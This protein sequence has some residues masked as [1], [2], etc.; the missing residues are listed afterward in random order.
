MKEINQASH[1]RVFKGVLTLL[2]SVLLISCASI[3]ELQVLYQL[4]PLSTQLEGRSVTLV[5]DDAR[6]SK[7]ILGKGAEEEFKGFS[8]SI[9]LSVA[10]ANKKGYR[11]GIF[12][13]PQLMREAFARKLETSGVKVLSEKTVGVPLLVIVLK[14]F[15]LDLVGREWLAKMSYEARLKG[16]KGAVANQ[17]INGK[18]ERYKLIGRD[19]ADTLMGEI[20]SDMVNALDLSRLFKQAGL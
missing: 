6:A 7:T 1:D 9:S 20:F 16:E 3:P 13:V 10:D 17:I 18:A 14:E 8:G 2:I 5:I 4:P 19:S 12:R 15:S 11:V